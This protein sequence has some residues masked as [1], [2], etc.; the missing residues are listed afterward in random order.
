MIFVGERR[1][2]TAR[3][4]NWTWR[5]GRLAARPLFEALN[6]MGIEPARQSYANLWTDH[7]RPTISWRCLA[8]LRAQHQDVVVALGRRVA[9]ELRR[10]GIEHVELVHPAARGRIRKRA[11]YIAHVRE[12]LIPYLSA[13]LYLQLTGVR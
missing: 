9:A 13:H 4:R 12:R 5:N 8:M 3:K 1:S 10:R 11:R 7:T 2:N 6:A